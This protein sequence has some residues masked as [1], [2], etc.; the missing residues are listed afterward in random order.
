MSTE[1]R[2]G[3]PFLKYP[4]GRMF[5]SVQ[6]GR[7]AECVRYCRD[8]DV[9]H[10]HLSPYHGFGGNDTDF[11]KDCPRVTDVHLQGG[12]FDLSGLYHLG[13]L[14]FLSAVFELRQELDLRRF[15]AL[16]ELRADWHPRRLAGLYDCPR[17]ARLVLRKYKP[18]SR[19]L[20]DLGRLASLE[21]LQLVQSPITSLAGVEA[22]S[23][24]WELEL[25]YCARLTDVTALAARADTLQ[26]LRL[27]RCRNV[28]GREGVARL[29][30]LTHLSFCG[31][32]PI[33]SIGFVRGMP[34]LRFFAFVGTDVLDGDMTPL[35]GLGY[36]GF[37]SK[38]HYSHTFEQVQ[39][40]IRDRGAADVGTWVWGSRS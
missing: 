31:D 21:S 30:R 14:T 28:A 26:R 35:L 6:S 23:R 25:H 39:Q 19:D 7:L 8:A 37:D 38:R 10:L 2:D 1:S 18:R 33:P 3:F 4:D 36:A 15:P 40:I 22:M 27:D 29:R 24:L 32:S 20:T 5:L 12:T 34:R 16:A 13:D 9:R 11:L 17:L